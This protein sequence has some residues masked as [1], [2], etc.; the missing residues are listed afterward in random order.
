MT[1]DESSAPRRSLDSKVALQRNAACAAGQ[2][3]S[4]ELERSEFAVNGTINV[5]DNAPTR[6]LFAAIEAQRLNL[7]NVFDLVRCISVGVADGDECPGP[8]ITAAF[9]LLECEIQRIAATLEE[10]SL[11]SAMNARSGSR[12]SPSLA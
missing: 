7:L 12:R 1:R 6:L 3:T 5:L 9:D 11:R 2:V 4:D 10:N 8:E